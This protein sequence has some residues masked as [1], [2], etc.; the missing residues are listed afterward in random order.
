MPW[1]HLGRVG[2]ECDQSPHYQA[3]QAIDEG[4]LSR[5]E[6]FTAPQFPTSL[7]KGIIVDYQADWPLS[8]EFKKGARSYPDLNAWVESGGATGKRD[9][10][11]T[12][13]GRFPVLSTPH[14]P[15]APG[16]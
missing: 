7:G 13:H 9:S 16:A 1:H 11:L 5:R 3:E 4:T 10:R 2:N 15:E 14:I 12:R 6:Q 8:T